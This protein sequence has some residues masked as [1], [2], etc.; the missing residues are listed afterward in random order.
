MLAKLNFLPGVKTMSFDRKDWMNDYMLN[1][2]VVEKK[3]KKLRDEELM[4]LDNSLW[5]SFVASESNRE[6]RPESELFTAVQKEVDRRTFA[7][8]WFWRRLPK[9]GEYKKWL[10]H[11]KETEEKAWRMAREITCRVDAQG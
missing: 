1:V 4:Q 10:D 9:P 7:A 5:D 11:N 2:R 6:L 8:G 3:L